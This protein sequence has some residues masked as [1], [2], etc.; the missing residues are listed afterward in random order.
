MF[1][2]LFEWTWDMPHLVFMGALG[3]A[4]TVLGIGMKYCI[5]MTAAKTFL[6][7]KIYEYDYYTYVEGVGNIPR[8]IFKYV[9]SNPLGDIR[10]YSVHIVIQHFMIFTSFI[11]LAS[12]GIPLHYS[13]VFWSIKVIT[14]L[15]G[16]DIARLIHR[17]AAFIMVAGSIYHSVTITWGVIDKIIKGKFDIRRTQ[18]PM[19]KDVLD[20]IGDIRYFLGD[21]PYRPKM[22]KF[23]YKQKLHYLAIIWGTTVL[24]VAGV[25]MLFPEFMATVWPSPKFAQDVARLMHADEAIMAVLVVVLWHWSNVHFAPGRFPIQWTFLTGMITR[26]HQIEEHFLEYIRNLD[27]MPEEKEYMRNL[28]LELAQQ[29]Q[30]LTGDTIEQHE[31]IGMKGGPE[32]VTQS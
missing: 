7:N 11:V 9:K 2:F 12:T 22:E 6:G 21:M 24:V 5:I 32:L 8:D 16:P 18:I 1:P 30:A 29:N 26:E 23:M 4:L 10:R 20:V 19:P 31:M 27:E 3:F 17:G 13:D 25:T 14:F 28:L 15:G